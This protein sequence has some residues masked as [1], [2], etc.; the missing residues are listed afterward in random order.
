MLTITN[1][2]NM[3]L[4]A[5]YPDKYFE[6]AIVDPPY[7]LKK[8]NA[9][10]NG[11]K[12]NGVVRQKKWIGGDWD[13]NKPT[14][15]YFNELQRVSKN[16]IIW[17]GNYFTDML[18]QSD[19]WVI[20][21]KMQRVNQSDCELAWTSF[22]GALRIFQFNCS[23]LQGFMNPLRFHPTE[24]P[25]NLYKWLLDKYAK[26]NDKILDTHLGSGSIAIACHDYGFD[27]TA[28][29]LDKEYFDKAI[30][31][32]NNHIKQLNLFTTQ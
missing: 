9:I 3:L 6:L 30:E 20:W 1:E 28:C 15:K 18:K 4:M 14:Q 25:I 22:T 24:K 19:N 11:D 31:R 21:D 12:K 5:R 26:P 32:I 7:G 23:K 29:E 10:G 16:Q 8:H 17:G 27:L 2:D 13:N